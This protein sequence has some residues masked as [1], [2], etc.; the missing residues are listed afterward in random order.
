LTFGAALEESLARLAALLEDAA[1]PWWIIGSVAVGLQ[2]G[3][4]GDISDID[5]VLSHSDAERY[6]HQLGLANGAPTGS[7]LFR[8]ELFACWSEPPV[9]VELMAGLQVNGPGGWEHLSIH[10]REEVRNGLYAPSSDELRAILQWFARPK[11]LERAATLPNGPPG[12][13]SRFSSRG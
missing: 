5:V 8:S 11:D 9:A 13:A 10:S 4:P 1:E 7:S 2:S 12:D 6:F 3:S